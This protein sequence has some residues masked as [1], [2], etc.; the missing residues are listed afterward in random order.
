VVTIDRSAMRSDTGE[1]RW[2]LS[3][4]GSNPF[5]LWV[6]TDDYRYGSADLAT[7]L[8]DGDTTPG[9]VAGDSQKTLTIPGTARRVITVGSYVTRNEWASRYGRTFHL[10]KTPI[11]SISSFSS[12]GPT[13]D[14]STTGEK[15]DLMAPGQLIAAPLAAGSNTVA[16]SGAIDQNFT[17]MQGT[18]M[19]APHVAGTVALLLELNPE[20]TPE[21]AKQILVETATTDGQFDGSTPNDRAGF[22]RLNA[23]AAVQRLDTGAPTSKGCHNV[24]TPEG[25]VLILTVATLMFA[26]T[27]FH[28]RMRLYRWRVLSQSPA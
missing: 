20:L 7:E 13:A 23:L 3:W 24:P 27:M 25:L 6:S 8:P 5:D 21:E 26:H 4:Q 15:P 2:F 10:D 16:Q 1:A 9:F 11:S 12:L 28:R 18:S 19:S 22:G 17:V 14:P